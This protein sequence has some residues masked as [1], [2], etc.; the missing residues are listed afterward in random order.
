VPLVRKQDFCPRVLRMIWD[1]HP[2]SA[3]SP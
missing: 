3:A 1:T 2:R